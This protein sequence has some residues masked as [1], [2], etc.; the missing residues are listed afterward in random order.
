MDRSRQ[1]A[2]LLRRPPG[3][4]A[5]L[6]LALVLAV[7]LATLPS[8]SVHGLALVG[9][10][11][12]VLLGTAWETS[13]VAAF[14]WTVL[15]V[16]GF[17]AASYTRLQAQP[18]PAPFALA[19]DLALLPLALIAIAAQ[20]RLMAEDRDRAL[21]ATTIARSKLL[22]SNTEL[23]SAMAASEAAL[24]KLETIVANLS[25]GL[26]AMRKDGRVEFGNPALEDLLEV[27]EVDADSTA[28]GILPKPLLLLVD[29]CLGSK[30]EEVAELTL[31]DGRVLAAAASPIHLQG[32]LWGA[33]VLIRDVTT[34]RQLDRMK[35][36]FAATVS[37]EMRTPLTSV[38]GFTKLI[39]GQLAKRVFPHVPEDD[40]R[41]QRSV[42]TIQS[43]LDVMLAEGNRLSALINDVMDISK[44]ESGQVVWSRE[45]HAPQG[46]VDEA[47]ARSKPAFEAQQAVALEV[48]VAPGLPDVDADRRRVLQVLD[49]LIR[50]ALKFTDAGT[51]TVGAQLDPDGRSVRFTVRDTGIGIRPSHQAQ[52]FE[53][54]KQVG[55]V[56]TD[57][58][59]GTGLGLPICRE[60][61]TQHGGRIAVESEPG[62]GSLFLFTLPFATAD[63][64]ARLPDG[65]SA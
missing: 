58:P 38:L 65:D 39:K 37:H 60:I 44:M 27:R 42:A 11:L 43:N 29:R 18:A 54:F 17:A 30:T 61:V 5:V 47:L 9:T 31:D 64:R 46:L 59:Q 26:L 13:R 63:T 24:V 55:D 57:R 25:D 36:D 19:T 40:A 51:V 35:S 14:A 3:A 28:V 20:G 45:A 49:N 33:V 4:R 12:L 21:A 41:A 48:D 32:E 10:C 7:A 56:L 16:A 34:Q 62:S 52:I 15:A 23:R 6:A 1:R 50:N 22:R 53:T 2:E 8:P